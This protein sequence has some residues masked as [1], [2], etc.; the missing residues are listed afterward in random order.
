MM[1]YFKT[2][3]KLSVLLIFMMLCLSPTLAQDVEASENDSL[4]IFGDGQN[5]S[6]N[7]DYD[8]EA[9]VKELYGSEA[10]P[11]TVTIFENHLKLIGLVRT[12]FVNTL[13]RIWKSI[14][15]CFLF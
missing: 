4:L 6:A 12:N 8:Y 11:D 3:Q 5:G 10:K 1:S 9:L 7:T 15:K 14:V 13:M 2:I